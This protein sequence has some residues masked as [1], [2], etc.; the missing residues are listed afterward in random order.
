M[1]IP[2]LFKPADLHKLAQSA[3]TCAQ[4]LRESVVNANS[5]SDTV[6][7]IDRLSDTICKVVD[8]AD[9]IRNV[10]P[11]DLWRDAAEHTYHMLQNAINSLNTDHEV[12]TAL[13]NAENS[14][15][16]KDESLRV[17]RSLRHDL[18]RTGIGLP[19]EQRQQLSAMLDQCISLG[20]QYQQ[21][22]LDATCVTDAT[23]SEA[24]C[25]ALPR[26]AA[27]AF[28]ARLRSRYVYESSDDSSIKFAA[29][30]NAVNAALRSVGDSGV[31]EQILKQASPRTAASNATTLQQ[32]L[33]KRQCVASQLGCSSFSHLTLESNLAQHPDGV[34]DFLTHLAAVVRPAADE[35]AHRLARLLHKHTLNQWDKEYA[36]LQAKKQV[37]GP[38]LQSQIASYFPLSV[39]FNGLGNLCKQLFNVELRSARRN[40]RSSRATGAW[41]DSVTAIE[42]FSAEGAGEKLGDIWLD[43][44]HR[45]GKPSVPAHYTV[46]C[47]KELSNGEY[48]TPQV[49]LVAAFE[50]EIS[51]GNA[52]TCLNHNELSTLLH[53]FGHALHTLLSRTHYQHL[54]GTRGP[55]DLVEIPSHIAE[56]YALNEHAM[57]LFTGDQ[58][59]PSELIQLIKRREAVCSGLDLQQQILYALV[60]IRLHRLANPTQ[61]NIENCVLETERQVSSI[62]PVAEHRWEQKFVHLVGYGASYYTYVFSKCFVS[63]MHEYFG[64]SGMLSPD[65]G[66]ALHDNLLMHGCAVDGTAALRNLLGEECVQQRGQAIVPQIP[67]LDVLMKQ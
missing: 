54:A 19:L 61:E 50:S 47:G 65:F 12:Y 40:E 49:A 42:L 37:M 34:E 20:S 31:R 63:Q 11:S 52:E 2:G 48:Q 51:G 32:L 8:P 62:E 55:L 43:L 10:H 14:G 24:E 6:E 22:L 59:I 60:D 45:A 28:P 25:V 26:Q 44:V 66:S 17:A 3:L 53:E 56:S 57:Q 4:S 58:P 30:D 67:N 39:V 5:A 21:A 35:E 15:E 36:M 46:R 13:R 1:S 29:S 9:L 41:H 7:A 23:H 16:L 27:S 33:E 18:E 38:H 64:E